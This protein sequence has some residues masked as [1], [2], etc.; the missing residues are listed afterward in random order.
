MEWNSE[1]VDGV[2]V[3]PITPEAPRRSSHH[4]VLLAL[5]ALTLVLAAG[6]TGF[7]VGHANQPSG[8]AVAKVGAAP[9]QFPTGGYGGYGNYGGNANAPTTPAANAPSSKAN[10]A[11]GKI[12]SS[13]DPGLVDITTQLSLQQGTAAGTGMVL[14]SNGL[15]L[16]NNHVIDGATSISVRDVATGKVYKATVVGYDVSSD[17]AVLQLKNASG[18]T[19]IKTDTGTVTKGES[20]VG[21]GNAGGTGGTPSYAA[22]TVLALGQSITASD[23]GNPTGSE[24]LTGMIEINAPI[25]PGD[26]GG[27]LANSSGQVIGMDTAASASNGP[28]FNSD[29][30]TTTQAFAIPIST[31]LAIATSIENGSSSSTVHIGKTAFIGIELA[32]TSPGP[33]GG[34]GNAQPGTTSGVTVAGTEAGTPAAKSAL[35]SGDVIVSVNGQ[36][37]TTTT[38]LEQILQTLKPGDSVTVGYTNTSGA[39]ATLNLVLG[40]GP[41]Q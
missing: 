34:F 33:T 13:V 40:S 1:Y 23:S 41:A 10:A 32:P 20:I 5:S 8:P 27:A 38:S 2:Q 16:T 3:E 17:I 24:T 30:T 4:R 35:T 28:V 31:A 12:A 18:L 39:Q 25:Q 6:L 21:I 14:S 11:A 7:F 22:G 9:P 29:S 15:V 26:S 19:T 36:S 37:V